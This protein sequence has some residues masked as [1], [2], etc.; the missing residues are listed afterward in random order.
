MTIEQERVKM[1]NWKKRGR[2]SAT[3]SGVWQGKITV[4]AV[5]P[6]VITHMIWRE[7]MLTAG[8]RKALQAFAMTNSYCVLH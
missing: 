3:G 6:G 1:A 2:M 4:P 5:M 8:A 7:V